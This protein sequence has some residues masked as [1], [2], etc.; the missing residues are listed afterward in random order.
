MATNTLLQRLDPSA[1]TTGSSTAASNRRQ[2]EDFLS[3]AAIA[4]GDVVALD[5]S[6]TGADRALYVKQ[7]AAVTHGN[8][9]AV[10]V[11]L[12]AAAGAGERVKVVVAGYVEGV[13]SGAAV[14]AAGDPLCPGTVAGE[15]E[16][17]AN[18]DLTGLFGV[19]LGP[20]AANKVDVHLFKRF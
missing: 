9:L 19:A 12:N 10:G 1:D 20:A 7:A 4:A 15:V 6:K 18:S 17:L 14:I 2:I 13:N 8:P 3:G 16:A 5:T 11:A